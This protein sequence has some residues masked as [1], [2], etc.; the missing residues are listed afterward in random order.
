MVGGDKRQRKSIGKERTIGNGVYAFEYLQD[1]TLKICESVVESV[2][3]RDLKAKTITI[4][5]KY[6]YDKQITR[7]FTFEDYHQNLETFSQA[8]K[9]LLLKTKAGESNVRLVGVTLSN[10]I[11]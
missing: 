1:L 3:K 6:R 10:F 4:K 8:C 9:N 7:S 5:M 11:G 2:K